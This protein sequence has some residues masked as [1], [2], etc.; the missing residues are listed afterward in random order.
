[1]KS[2][3]QIIAL[4]GLL[5]CTGASSETITLPV[6]PVPGTTLSATGEV[7]FP[8]VSTGGAKIAVRLEGLDP[9]TTYILCLNPWDPESPTS[10]LLG[11]IGLHGW[12]LGEIY[13]DPSSGVRVGHWNF[14]RIETDANGSFSHTYDLPLPPFDYSIRMLIKTAHSAG[15]RTILQTDSLMMAVN[16]PMMGRLLAGTVVALAFVPLIFIARGRSRDRRRVRLRHYSSDTGDREP[17]PEY[18]TLVERARAEGILC[19][20]KRYTW[21]EIHNRRKTFRP[22]QALVFQILCEHDPN[23]DGML[24]ED[25]V[26]EWEDVF[27]AKRANPVRVRDIFRASP[28]EP[29]DF[30]VRV[31]GPASAYK[32][33]LTPGPPPDSKPDDDA[34]AP[35]APIGTDC[36]DGPPEPDTTDLAEPPRS[37]PE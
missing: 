14:A 11:Q 28:D 34:P 1:M 7:D 26:K 2:W 16:P 6:D 9:D 36:S 19:H 17:A 18:H 8:A 29:G 4:A 35:T 22:R 15:S 21:I 37:Y 27:S 13:E 32:L 10:E 20:N 5:A 12:P 3:I 30:I 31:P 23:C 33:R 25:I 24:Q